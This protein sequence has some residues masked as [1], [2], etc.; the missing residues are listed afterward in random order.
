MARYLQKLSL[1]FVALVWLTTVNQA[2]GQVP[3]S[4]GAYQQNFDE[5]GQAGTALPTGW[6]AVRLAGSGL[7]NQALVPVVSTGNSTSGAVYNVGSASSADRALGSLSSSTTIPAFGVVFK[8]TS[9]AAITQL[10]IDAVMEQW[11]SGS[12]DDRLESLEFEYS[13]N[14]TSIFSGTWVAIPSL[15]LV[16]K[17]TATNIAEAVDGNQAANRTPVSGTFSVSL[18]D[19]ATLYL[20]WK[21]TDVTGSDGLYALDDL[22]VTPTYNV[23]DTTFP[24]LTF[25]AP[26]AGATG[27]STQLDLLLRFSEQILAGSGRVL[28]A[29][30]GGSLAWAATDPSL[31]YH[32]N[33]VTIK[34]IS[35]LPGT[36]YTVTVEGLAFKDVAGNYF[37]GISGDA[38]SFTTSAIG[39]PVLAASQQQLRFTDTEI[40]KFS[41]V[42][43]YNLSALYL[44]E[45][46]TVTA[47]GPFQISKTND[48]ASFSTASL[49]FSAA[50]LAS[51]KPIFVRFA[52][53][54][55]SQGA[56]TITQTSAGAQPLTVA[57]AGEA[58]SAQAQDFN[59]CDSSLPGG[60]T[61]FSVEGAQ[62]WA[63]TTFGRSGNAVQISGFA[64]GNNPNQDW[65]ISPALNLTSGFDYPLLSFWSRT[66][67]AGGPL[68][69][70]VSSNY[71]GTGSPLAEGV[72]WTELNGR[73]P[74]AQSD[75]W[76]QSSGIDLSA[77]KGK[78]I[79]VAFVYVST[80]SAAPRWTLDDVEISNSATAPP[81]VLTT[82]NALSDL[83]FG[84]LSPGD[85]V[86]KTFGFS[87]ENLFS[88][89]SLS[90]PAPFLLSRNG[91]DFASTIS[92]SSAEGA[93]NNFTIR[94]AAPA[95]TRKA[96]AATVKFKAENLDQTAGY[97]TGAVL[98][99]NHTFDVVTWNIEWFGAP[100]QGPKNE[101]LQLA[102]VKKVIESLDADVYAFQE[103][104]E[105]NAFGAL[106][107][108]LPA[109]DGFMSNYPFGSQEIAYL[110]KKS[111]VT[112]INQ[113]TL[114]NGVTGVPNFWASGRLPYLL[115]IDATLDGITKRLHLINIHAKANE[116]GSA[117]EAQ[118]AYN[119]RKEDVRILKDSL[120]LY[121]ATANIIMLGDYN[122]DIDET[123][124]D[125][126]AE[127]ASTYQ[128]IVDDAARY[129][130]PTLSLSQAGLRSY[131]SYDNVIDHIMYSNELANSYISHSARIDIPFDVVGAS[132]AEV[133]ATTTSDHLPTIARFAF[134]L[135]TGAQEESERKSFIIFPN[136]TSGQVSFQLPANVSKTANLTLTAYGLR[137]EILLSVS[138]TQEFLNA[139]LS[140][141]ISASSAGLYLVRVQ[142]GG[143]TFLG[144]IMKN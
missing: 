99:T 34:K 39:T 18:A 78:Q 98:N 104:S 139:K 27:V 3:L 103:I 89:V 90:V 142:A 84:I 129:T 13:T 21:D 45:K 23:V 87:I 126:A 136:P 122:D 14:A 77:F 123:V 46:V 48:A 33:E 24:L 54:A 15:D 114:L 61:Q 106:K 17:L 59:K 80:S 74:G 92:F 32:G 124:A 40:G 83:D 71:S 97:F 4:G 134:D 63:C 88:A 22:T 141:T 12:R 56:G 102:N 96:Y 51:A 53:M 6:T 75:T 120:D 130:F 37:G 110:Y 8:N 82:V 95:G 38:Y 132:S 44:Q 143:Q 116:N 81:A 66:A 133:F 105:P 47:T 91:T 140:N 1:L 60:W 119:R 111:T 135:P 2:F 65:L 29:W 31:S 138:G 58:Y 113:K 55:A 41:E 107:A 109:Y 19:G 100:N 28:L 72:T 121:Y 25:T 108:L 137:G 67:F 42:Q 50:D 9:G 11:R 52:P 144:R 86:N 79:Y 85:D 7:T 35:L 70:K 125:L 76:V 43:S 115:E 94:F 30:P 64:G 93:A 57:L 68:V 69:L 36:R 128:V 117:A 26:A 5:M 73:F 10:K 118:N 20:R 131:I 112:K 101:A 62:T 49:E 16:E 127:R